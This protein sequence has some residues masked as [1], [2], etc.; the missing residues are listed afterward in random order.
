MNQNEP[1]TPPEE[2]ELTKQAREWLLSD[3]GKAAIDRAVKK[4]DK[5]KAKLDALMQ[6]ADRID[7]TVINI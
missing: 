5:F 4:S 3:E 1:S 2:S 7:R 6:P